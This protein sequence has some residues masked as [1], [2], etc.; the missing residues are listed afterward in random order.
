M[1]SFQPEL[2]QFV[3]GNPHGD[4]ETPEWVDALIDKLLSEIERVCWNTQQVEWDRYGDPKL[5]GVIF[6]P[7]YWGDKA[8]EAE[9]PNLVFAFSPQE[10]RWYKHPGRGQSAAIEFSNSQWIE[11]FGKALDLIREADIE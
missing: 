8:E 4:F 2:G 7:Y 9:K 10:I 6:R 5:P 1:D 11:W 3:F